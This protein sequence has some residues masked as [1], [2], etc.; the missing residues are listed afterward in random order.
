MIFVCGDVT[1][2]SL[3]RFAHAQWQFFCLI[4]LPCGIVDAN[5]SNVILRQG[6]TLPENF[7]GT[8]FVWYACYYAYYTNMIL[9]VT[10]RWRLCKIGNLWKWYILGTTNQLPHWLRPRCDGSCIEYCATT[11]QW[12]VSICVFTK[13]TKLQNFT[14]STWWIFEKVVK[15]N[16]TLQ[17]FF[18]KQTNN[19]IKVKFMDM[20][21]WDSRNWQQYNA[22]PVNKHV[23]QRFP[24]LAQ[25]PKCTPKSYRWFPCT[26]GYHINFAKHTAL[27]Q[28][29]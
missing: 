13:C 21:L 14:I 6:L 8:T 22:I 1:V 11:W 25:R 2:R 23:S 29:T 28:W 15:T 26:S 5:C 17:L 27:H 18:K 16:T 4:S 9:L 24:W 7:G 3:L 19:T 12:L 10:F 20:Y